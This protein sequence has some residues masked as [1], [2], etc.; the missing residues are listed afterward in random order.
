MKKVVSIFLC[1]MLVILLCSTTAFA[2]E[3]EDRLV[4]RTVE[5]LENGDCIVYE[6]YENYIQP[7]ATKSGYK[8]A[9]YQNSAGRAIWDVTV[10]GSFTYTYGVSSKATSASAIVNIYDSGVSFQSKN[11]YTAG[12]TAYATAVVSYQTFTTTL[13][14]SISC[15]VYG[16]L[17]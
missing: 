2:A 5:K 7:L 3:T 9:T 13:N 4:S 12:N 14:V 16:N 8:T 15:D 10:Q 17:S 11:A 6:V 1:L